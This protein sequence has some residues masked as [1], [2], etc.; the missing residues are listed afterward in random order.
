MVSSLGQSIRGKIGL[1][2][3]LIVTAILAITGAYHHEQTR[4]AF[5]TELEAS[6]DL[7]IARLAK[8]L[9]YPLWELDENWVVQVI[10]TEMSNRNV[11]A[12]L[13]KG[14]GMAPVGRG[15]D[16]DWQP[17]A[18]ASPIGDDMIQRQQS[19][20]NHQNQIGT[21]T[22]WVT[23]AFTQQH[24]RQEALF[25]VT[26]ALI[27]GIALIL[28]LTLA[29]N[30]VIVQPLQKINNATKRIAVGDYGQDIEIRQQDEIG[31]L[32]EI[33]NDMQHSIRHRETELQHMQ[34]E[35]RAFNFE[36][37]QRVAERTNELRR[38]QAFTET[39]L[40][41]ISDGIV[42]CDEH[43]NLSLFNRATRELH[44][45]DQ[46]SLAPDQWAGRY[47]L[48]QADGVSILPTEQIP[49]FRAFQG[50][51][52]RGQELV[53]ERRDH[54]QKSLLCS[55]QAMYD[56][57]GNKVGAVVSMHDITTEKQ[58][59][60]E[61]IQARDVAEEANR[62]KSIFLAN[63]S[64]ELRTPLN[65]ILGFSELLAC[66]PEASSE[67]QEKLGV[68]NRSGEHLLAM[69]NDVLDLSKVEAG[70]MALEPEPFELPL[71]LE[72]I[73]RMFEVRAEGAG[74]QF[75]LEVDP[76]LARYVESDSGK[77]RQ[78][79]INLLGNAVKF[80]KEGGVTL[81]AR[82]L[83]IDGDPDRISLQLEVEDT[84]R[85]IPLEQQHLIFDPFVQAGHSEGLALKGTGLG[86]AISKSFVELI[87]GSIQVTSEPGNGA[88]FRVELPVSLADAEEVSSPP[89]DAM[90]VGLQSDQPS[91]RILVVEDQLENRLLLRNCLEPIGFEVREAENGR[92]AIAQ[93]EQWQP[94]LIWMDMRMPVMDG[95]EATRNIRC[96]PGGDK[97]RILA[98]TAS[99]FKEQNQR[100]LDEGCDAVFHKPFRIADIF[101]AMGDHLG[102][103]YRYAEKSTKAEAALPVVRLTTA[104]LD[105]L[106]PELQKA[107]REATLRLDVEAVSD[108]IGQVRS[109]DVGIADALGVL[110]SE[111]RFDR[112]LDLLGEDCNE[113]IQ[114]R[115]SENTLP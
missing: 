72:D 22:L 12:I 111:F 29:L 3:L 86:L 110:L 52:I 7:I 96:M 68:I 49:L 100:T 5:T 77:L 15:R 53:I 78:I 46:E 99:V 24:F 34:L 69:I 74:L 113:S 6:S 17:V 60:A 54:T 85:G 4:A 109:T 62:A 107:L 65:A 92:E 79:L 20:F 80:T 27:V 95:F 71:L 58:V 21:V 8:N 106:S 67:Q 105:V 93:F 115:K 39:V 83:S 1:L 57:E 40:E 91:W 82:T 18:L 114:L 66:D 56:K 45:I 94:H 112:I 28:A 48:L 10:D 43:G 55:G 88:I 11:F 25:K 102:V 26:L 44:G 90:V 97:V 63:M 101:T 37:E 47:R 19:V 23:Q 36:L 30:R 64:H 33:V 73:R 41:Y 38:A 59:E 103:R 16:S 13:V 81:R 98:L 89:T 61:L 50:Q 31:L 76:A 51:Q 42:A 14:E 84:G 2:V 87:G 32:A 75:L 35:L 108:V 9:K 104:K 70:A